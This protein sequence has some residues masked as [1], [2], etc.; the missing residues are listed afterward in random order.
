LPAPTPTKPHSSQR[1]ERPALHEA[2]DDATLYLREGSDSMIVTVM[3]E[4][5]VTEISATFRRN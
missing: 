3:D 2:V 4:G 1:C 5:K